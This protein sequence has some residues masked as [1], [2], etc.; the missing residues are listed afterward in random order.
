[1]PSDAAHELA[2][3]HLAPEYDAAGEDKTAVISNLQLGIPD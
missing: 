2:D 1:M 3:A